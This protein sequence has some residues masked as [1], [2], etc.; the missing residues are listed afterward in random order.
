MVKTSKNVEFSNFVDSLVFTFI[1]EAE[2]N[3]AHT[4]QSQDVIKRSLLN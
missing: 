1:S 3:S 2:G 4:A